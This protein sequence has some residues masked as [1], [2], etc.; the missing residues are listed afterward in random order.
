MDEP[1]TDATEGVGA[2]FV[3][4]VLSI[5]AMN[6]IE[7]GQHPSTHFLNQLRQNVD[8]LASDEGE[9]PL[10]EDGK[11]SLRKLHAHLLRGMES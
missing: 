2:F 7:S 1:I 3:A 6:R 5:R 11:A 8:I 4:L 10:S 9:Y